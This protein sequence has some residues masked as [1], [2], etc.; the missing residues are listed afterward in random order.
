MNTF[1]KALQREGKAI[2]F[3]GP[4]VDYSAL[5]GPVVMAFRRQ[6]QGRSSSEALFDRISKNLKDISQ[7]S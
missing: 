4:Y 2:E 1:K 5:M 3:T 7:R 6:Q